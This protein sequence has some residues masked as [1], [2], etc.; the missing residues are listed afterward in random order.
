MAEMRELGLRGGCGSFA[1]PLLHRCPQS[2]P[3]C[4]FPSFHLQAL[5]LVGLLQDL[6]KEGHRLRGTAV[7]GQAL[8]GRSLLSPLPRLHLQT[9]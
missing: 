1:S 6:G 3:A 5:N 7:P 8:G 9:F 2:R 4:A